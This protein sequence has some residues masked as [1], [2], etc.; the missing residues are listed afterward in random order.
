M[1][2]LISFL[3]GVW[4]AGKY[5]RITMNVAMICQTIIEPP[6]NGGDI[7]RDNI[8]CKIIYTADGRQPFPC[9]LLPVC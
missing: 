9:F 5:V 6:A 8:T 3:W 4:Q 2:I 7:T 1:L